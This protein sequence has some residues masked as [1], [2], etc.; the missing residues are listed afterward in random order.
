[1]SKYKLHAINL[2]PLASTSGRQQYAVLALGKTNV[3]PDEF[4]A[5]LHQKEYEKEMED[6]NGQKE[7]ATK[8]P[9]CT[10][11]IVQNPATN[12]PRVKY[13]YFSN[14]YKENTVDDHST[15]ER[16]VKNVCKDI[17]N[18]LKCNDHNFNDGVYKFVS[19]YK[20]LVARN[21]VSAIPIIASA[22]RTFATS[23]SYTKKTINQEKTG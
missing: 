1:M 5:C 19:R 15:L 2:I 23:H 9:F 20:A 7:P 14:S 4:Y 3:Q 11:S 8:K 10:A 6:T 18:K 17:L 16:D 13:T 21:D 12:P 22:L